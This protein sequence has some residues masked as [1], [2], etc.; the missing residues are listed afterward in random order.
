MVMNLKNL[1]YVFVG[2][3]VLFTACYDES[4]LV[5]DLEESNS[6]LL[7][8]E[9]PQGTNS[10]DKDLKEIQEKFGVYVIYKD[11]DSTDL[12]RSWTGTFVGTK[13]YGEG[14]ADEQA[15][16]VVNFLKNHIFANLTPEITERVFPMYW[17]IVYDSHTIFDLGGIMT[18]KLAAQYRYDGLDFWSM[19][20]FYGEP[21]PLQGGIETPE[22]DEELWEERVDILWNILDKA[23]ENGNIKV[24]DTFYTRFDYETEIVYGTGLELD[25]NYYVMRGFP[26]NFY[27]ATY[28]NG[29]GFYQL[30]SIDGISPEENFLEYIHLCMWK[31]EEELNM[32]WPKATYALLWEMRAFVID[33]MKNTYNIDLEAIARGP[34]M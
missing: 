31:T 17:F 33:Y 23:F 32:K 26:G 11:I 22:T 3:M 7:R 8:F 4:P 15:E 19:C 9:F 10:W 29:A 18:M 30:T 6:G 2:C 34:I 25:A 12:N 14:S 13:Y 27:G 5:A 1:F 16:Y 24:P 28:N 20:W 21:D